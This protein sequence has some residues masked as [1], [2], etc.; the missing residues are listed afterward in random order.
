MFATHTSLFL[1][2]GISPQVNVCAKCFVCELHFRSY[3]RSD[4]GLTNS[5]TDLAN[6]NQNHDL[7]EMLDVTGMVHWCLGKSL[8]DVMLVHS[9]IWY[10]QSIR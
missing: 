8:E 5:T 3:R 4:A 2:P 9:L 1:D 7:M 6:N 10:G